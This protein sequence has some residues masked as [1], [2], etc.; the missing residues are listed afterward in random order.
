MKT[1][2]ILALDH[3]GYETDRID[4]D[5]IKA[6]KQWVKDTGVSAFYW[7]RRAESATFA[8]DYIHTLQLHINGELQ[9]EWFPRFN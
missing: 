8:A 6:A 2:E 5:T 3:A 4:F 7:E 1:I 9:T